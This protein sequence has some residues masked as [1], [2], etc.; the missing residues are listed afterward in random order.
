MLIKM[1]FHIGSGCRVGLVAGLLI[2]S[3]CVRNFTHK[4]I[5]S[6]IA[7]GKVNEGKIINAWQLPR[8]AGN[9]RYYSSFSYYTLGRSYVHSLVYKTVMDTYKDMEAL[10]PQKKFRLAECSRR[11]GGK[12]FPHRTHQN[13]TSVDFMTPLM[14]KEKKQKFYDGLGIFVYLLNFDDAGTRA[15]GKVKIDYNTMA[16]HILLLEKNARK[17]GLKI[18]KVIFKIELQDDLFASEKG[19]KLKKTDIYFVQK[20]SPLINAAHD[21]HYHID[22]EIHKDF[23]FF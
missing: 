13:G 22:F 1:T 5:G 2:L 18:K 6:S 9:M 7:E 3:S 21:D 8:K 19:R 14:K 11:K 15:H 12:M 16:D 4:N 17:N 23:T 20:L 10:Y